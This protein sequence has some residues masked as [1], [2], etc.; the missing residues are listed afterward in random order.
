MKQDQLQVAVLVAEM[1]PTSAKT[2]SGSPWK[3]PK[4][5]PAQWNTGWI[6]LAHTAIAIPNGPNGLTTPTL[7][8]LSLKYSKSLG[9]VAEL[10]GACSTQTQSHKSKALDQNPSMLKAQRHEKDHRYFTM[11]KAHGY[12]KYS[13]NVWESPA[14]PSS[15]SDFNCFQHVFPSTLSHRRGN[16]H[17]DRNRSPREAHSKPV[18]IECESGFV[19]K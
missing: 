19:W 5:G 8:C 7:W 10:L 17:R 18:S 13:T 4:T 3:P 12:R 14:T 6:W 9:N 16:L 11:F 15:G 1:C 2:G